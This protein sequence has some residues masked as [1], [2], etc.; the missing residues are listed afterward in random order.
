MSQP[1]LPPPPP[2]A[3]YFPA[4]CQ[5]MFSPLPIPPSSTK[6]AITLNS[7]VSKNAF[8][9]N[10]SFRRADWVNEH[11]PKDNVGYDIILV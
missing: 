1:Y 2:E 7:G 3:D 11:I 5:H 4:S 9:H 8:P 6:T 10:V